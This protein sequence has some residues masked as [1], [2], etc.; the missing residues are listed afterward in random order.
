[1]WRRW[2]NESSFTRFHDRSDLDFGIGDGEPNGWHAG[3]LMGWSN[4]LYSVETQW[5]LD[6]FASGTTSL[7]DLKKAILSSPVGLRI[8][9]AP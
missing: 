1:M 5:M 8:I 4:Q 9:T 6:D 3:Y 7:L 2:E